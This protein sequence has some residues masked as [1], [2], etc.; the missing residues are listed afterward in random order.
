MS[1]DAETGD[2]NSVKPGAIDA[3]FNRRSHQIALHHET[4][5]VDHGGSSLLGMVVRTLG[6]FAIRARHRQPETVIAWHRKGFHLFWTRKA[7]IV[8]PL[9]R[10][11]RFGPAVRWH[12]LL[13]TVPEV[14][15]YA[16]E[17]SVQMEKPDLRLHS[18][19]CDWYHV[20]TRN[21]SVTQLWLSEISIILG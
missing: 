7:K 6:R 8:V 12:P 21:R 17:L 3:V 20:N 2:Q 4:A 14:G 16:A 1:A 10:A 9:K 18:V 5:E 19:T 15:S 11:R 13:R